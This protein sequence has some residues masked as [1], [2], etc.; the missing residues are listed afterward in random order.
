MDSEIKWF[1]SIM[2]KAKRHTICIVFCVNGTQS[3]LRPRHTHTPQS[4]AI[5]DPEWRAQGYPARTWWPQ[6]LKP[7]T[8]RPE[9]LSTALPPRESP[10]APQSP[11]RPDISWQET[12]PPFCARRTVSTP[13]GGVSGPSSSTQISAT[14]AEASVTNTWLCQ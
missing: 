12:E 4:Y 6:D 1:C 11:R 3:L 8:L 13:Q 14:E 9:P 5:Q 7:E 10:A 2:S